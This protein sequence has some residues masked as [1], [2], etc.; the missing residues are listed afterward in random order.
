[1]SAAHCDVVVVGGGAT[2][3]AAAWALARRGLSVV[4]L[5]RQAAGRSTGR[6]LPRDPAPHH[7]A[8]LAE[9]RRLWRELAAEGAPPVTPDRSAPGHLDAA[10]VA[11]ALQASA[12]RHGA[13]L[14]FNRRVTA[15]RRYGA[16]VR[17]HCAAGAAV[18]ARAAVV[19]VGTRAG[20]VLDCWAVP[21]LAPAAEGRFVLDR[22][23]PVVV[24]AG[25]GRDGYA[26]LPAVG[27]VLADLAAGPAPAAPAVIRDVLV[28]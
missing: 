23:G 20:E 9:A 16:G 5:E 19:A 12:T 10:A 14:R 3:S 7:G 27:R 2:G 26:A 24:A 1:M 11:A 25:A 22:V 28:G 18:A 6:P 13:V 4:V 17:V 21:L 8:L 15:V